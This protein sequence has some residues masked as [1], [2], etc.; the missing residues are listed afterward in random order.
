MPLSPDY[1]NTVS[2]SIPPILSEMNAEA[3]QS[4]E[5]ASESVFHGRARLFLEFNE[6][7]KMNVS[8][9]EMLGIINSAGV[10]AMLPRLKATRL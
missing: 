3:R 2:S 7:I 6:E 5:P 1:G 8:R 10:S 4:S 9:E